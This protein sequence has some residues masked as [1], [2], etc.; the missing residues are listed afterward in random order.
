M[1][2]KDLE[3]HALSV[4]QCEKILSETVEGESRA[5]EPSGTREALQFR[6]GLRTSNIVNGGRIDATAV[7]PAGKARRP[8]VRRPQRDRIG[9]AARAAAL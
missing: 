3:V 5:T 4:L 2:V 9:V 1:V 6:L 8:G 7:A